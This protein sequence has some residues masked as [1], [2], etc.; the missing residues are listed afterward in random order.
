MQ[1]FVFRVIPG[2]ERKCGERERT[3]QHARERERQAS[4]QAAHPENVLLV[5]HRQYYGAGGQEQQRLEERVRHQME[6]RAVVCAG[7]FGQK[8]VTDL[9]HCRIRENFLDVGLHQRGQ[10]GQQQRNRAD[11]TDTLQRERA[12]TRTAVPSARSDR[13]PP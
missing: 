11:R 13:R 7:A 10:A 1:D 3:D 4:A 12:T 6:H 5:M 9:A 8:H 2:R